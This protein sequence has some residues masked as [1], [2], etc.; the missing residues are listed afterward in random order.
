VDDILIFADETEVKH[1]EDFFKAEFTWITMNV[2][3][4]LSYLGMQIMLSLGGKD[5]ICG[6]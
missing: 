1:I 5:V 6:R 4:A 3:N 2:E